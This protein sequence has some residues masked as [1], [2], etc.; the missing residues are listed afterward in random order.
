ME[1]VSSQ[2]YNFD[3]IKYKGGH[4]RLISALDERL[5]FIGRYKKHDAICARKTKRNSIQFD[6][7]GFSFSIK[8]RKCN[9]VGIRMKGRGNYFNVFVNGNIR[10][11]IKGSI[12]AG[13]CEGKKFYHL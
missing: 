11:V 6:W 1:K 10:C 7:P 5:Y 2:V 13:C 3:I 12:K 8:V 9:T 4:Y